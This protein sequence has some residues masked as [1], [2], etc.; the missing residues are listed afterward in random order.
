MQQV[1]PFPEVLESLVSMLSYR[2]GWSFRLV[3]DLDRG[4]GSRGLTLVINVTG[5]N[6]YPPHNV[7]SVNHY[8]VV[9]AAAFDGRSWRRWLFDQIGLVERHE[10]MEWFEIDGQK[11]YAPSHGPGNDPYL[12]RELGTDTDRRTSFRGELNPVDRGRVVF[13][14]NE[15]EARRA[16]MFTDAPDATAHFA[17]GVDH[18]AI[19][20]SALPRVGA[21]RIEGG[22]V[23]YSDEDAVARAS[24]LFDVPPELLEPGQDLHPDEPIPYRPTTPGERRG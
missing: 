21:A 8:M 11:M 14:H 7:M 1:A 23:R 12:V 17:P 6:S 15:V 10:R 5:P 20:G 9:P 19:P 4:Q 22:K 24:R 18:T 2:D 3:T 16:A 13:D